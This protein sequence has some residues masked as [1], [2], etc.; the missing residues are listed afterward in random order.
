MM[1]LLGA[2]AVLPNSP[3]IQDKLIK[4]Y[5]LFG[6]YTSHMH[7]VLKVQLLVIFVGCRSAMLSP[8]V[9]V[10]L[11]GV[12]WGGVRLSALSTSATIEPIVPA[13]DDG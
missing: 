3:T 1:K 11:F 4:R 9:H 7:A 6:N 8:P 13:P 10:S 2:F 12:S 5:I